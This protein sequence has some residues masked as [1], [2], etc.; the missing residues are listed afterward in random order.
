MVSWASFTSWTRKIE[1]PCNKATVCKTE[2]PFNA[3][4]AVTPN[5]FQIMVLRDKPAKMG[6]PN[7]LKERK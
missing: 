4:S 6:A 7:N 5:S 3:S 1:A 2:D